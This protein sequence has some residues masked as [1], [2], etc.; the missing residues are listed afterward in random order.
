MIYAV[1]EVL[2]RELINESFT[3]LDVI[4]TTTQEV[5][6]QYKIINNDYFKCIY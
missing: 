2:T 1:V 6:I 4:R 5:I 3:V